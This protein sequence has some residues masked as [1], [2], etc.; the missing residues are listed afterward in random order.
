MGNRTAHGGGIMSG[1]GKSCMGRE[2]SCAGEITAIV[3]IYLRVSLALCFCG[4][5]V[6]P[7]VGPVK[8]AS[9]NRATNLV[10]PVL[11]GR[12]AF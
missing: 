11:V 12:L 3:W 2:E 9:K 10:V 4:A 8:Q 5:L 6:L 7:Y 1:S